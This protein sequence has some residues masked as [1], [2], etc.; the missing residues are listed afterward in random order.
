MP[1]LPKQASQAQVLTLRA[2]AVN[3]NQAHGFQVLKHSMT[4]RRPF[5]PQHMGACGELPMIQSSRY[6]DA[7]LRHPG[8]F[9]PLL[10][11]TFILKKGRRGGEGKGEGMREREK[12][13]RQEERGR[14]GKRRHCR[15]FGRDVIITTLSSPGEDLS[16]YQTASH[17]SKAKP[18]SPLFMVCKEETRDLVF[19]LMSSPL[20]RKLHFIS[21]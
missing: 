8:C 5:C 17:N 2:P 1:E 19:L 9:V 21:S 6:K 15:I 11:A 4:V 18:R 20:N 16:I 12:E 14:R 10:A 3:V 7:S 13:R